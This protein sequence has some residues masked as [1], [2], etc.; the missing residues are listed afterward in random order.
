[1]PRVFEHESGWEVTLVESYVTI[2]DVTLVGCDGSERPFNMFWGPCPE[3]LRTE[4][5]ET[6]TVAGLR[7][8]PGQYCGL[9]LT[10]G[11]YEEPIIDEDAPTQHE[12]PNNVSAITGETI[13]LRGG[14][15][16]APGEDIV[17]FELS[18]DETITVE[19]DISELEGGRPMSV[20]HQEDFPKELTISKTYDQFL[21]G[22]DFEQLDED[23][24]EARLA[25]ILRQQTRVVLGKIVSPAL[26]E[27]D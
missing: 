8:S 11:P 23:A 2:A 26:F 25:D 4:D 24:I 19:L 16:P 10:Y 20:D 1:M 12:P 5:L 3:D 6:L 15:R 17:T 27:L 7:A 22:V 18:T 13:Y 21:Q 14:A 9:R